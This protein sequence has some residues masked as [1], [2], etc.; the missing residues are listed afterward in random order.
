MKKKHLP[1]SISEMKEYGWGQLDFI[2][3]SGD[4]YVDHPSFGVA[5]IS[6]ILEAS[7]Y[8]VGII[9]QPD[10]KD[11]VDFKKLGKPRLAYLVS[12]GN[13]DSMVNHYS[14][15]KKKRKKDAYSPNGKMGKRP[16]RATIVY[17][18][19]IREV[20]KEAN[21]IIGGIEASLRR[22][23]HYDYWQD[24]IRKSVLIDSRADLLIYGMAEKT[25][26]EV[27]EYLDKGVPLKSLKNIRGTVCVVDEI[28]EKKLLPLEIPSHNEVNSDKKKYAES[29]RTQYQ[30]SNP[31]QKNVLY[32]KTDNRYIKE[33]PASLPLDTEEMDYIYNLPYTREFHPM[34]LSQGGVPALEEVKFS[35]AAN[36]GCFGGCSF[37][38]LTVHQGKIIQKRSKQSIVDEAKQLSEDTDFKGYIHDIGGPTANFRNPACDKQFKYG[39]C[40]D[41]DCLTPEPCEKLNVSHEEYLDIL[42]T[43]RTLP[44]IKKVFIRSGIRF[45]YLMLEK[46][47]HFFNELIKHHISGQL[48]V[49]PEHCS[50]SVLKY[51]NKPR[52]EVYKK[53]KQKYTN[54][55]KK[56]NM[57]QYIVPYFISSHPGCTLEDSIMLFEYIKT[58]KHSPEQVQDFYPT[59][60]TVATAMYYSGIDIFTNEKIYVAKKTE[61][62]QMQRALLQPDNPRNRKIIIKALKMKNRFDLVDKYYSGNKNNRQKHN[63]KRKKRLDK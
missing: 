55:N 35:I 33:N 10:W 46:N 19:R 8:R 54:V 9:P 47:N 40:V 15:N 11:T 6:R 60:G 48:K 23:S 31:F 30:Y 25:L 18:N 57:N 5:I 28:K 52:F 53:F 34:Y 63:K 39:S 27:A 29:V 2:I 12:A 37:C 20:D 51:M 7:G 43:V 14:V 44:K 22:F 32:Q 36:R 1:V 3:I 50:D 42:Q 26:I 62:K 56:F 24:K 49:A 59:P 4:A 38:A 17:C 21:I 45:D 61:E 13:L 16:D 41:K 58:M